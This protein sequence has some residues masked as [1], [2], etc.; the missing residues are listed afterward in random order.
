MKKRTGPGGNQ[1]HKL[2]N[3]RLHTPGSGRIVKNKGSLYHLQFSI[4]LGELFPRIFALLVIR[5]QE[6][7]V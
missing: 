3:Q 1:A 2:T 7:E 6:E 4:T 5:F